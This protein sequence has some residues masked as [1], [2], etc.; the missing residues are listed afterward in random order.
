VTETPVLA[1]PR[2]TQPRRLKYQT[3]RVEAE[4]TQ[5]MAGEGYQIEAGPDTDLPVRLAN[6]G[7]P[8]TP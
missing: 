5:V 7:Q 1:S 4:I 6:M 8:L 3:D 2:M